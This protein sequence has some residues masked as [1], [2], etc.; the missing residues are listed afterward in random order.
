MADEFKKAKYYNPEI[1][2]K[3]PLEVPFCKFTSF[4]ECKMSIE[5]IVNMPL[6][7]AQRLAFKI[8][9]RNANGIIDEKDIIELLT[10]GEEFEAMQED[11]HVIIKNYKTGNS[12]SLNSSRLKT[13]NLP[14][15]QRHKLS[16]ISGVSAFSTDKLA[17]ETIADASKVS[18]K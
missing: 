8:Y 12:N 6:K 3:F 14:R 7:S 1:D 18:Q 16:E 13:K 15:P 10:I 17:K 2:R 11:M 5:R 9:D 4:K